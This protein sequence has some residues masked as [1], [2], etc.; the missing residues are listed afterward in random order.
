MQFTWSGC[1]SALA[2]PL[3]LDL[4]RLADLASRRGE[5]GVLEH[6]S[7]YFKAP[8]GDAVDHDFHRQMDLLHRY[9]TS[10]GR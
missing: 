9:A 8:L 4:A 2:A 10:I 5:S 6:L 1:D 7:C 3:V